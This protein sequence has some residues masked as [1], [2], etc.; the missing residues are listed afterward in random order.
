MN[1]WMNDRGVCRAAPGFARSDKHDENRAVHS[2]Q[3]LWNG[4]HYTLNWK[5]KIVYSDSCSVIKGQGNVA[6]EQWAVKS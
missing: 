2:K 4:D 5:L 1:E 3:G 6:S